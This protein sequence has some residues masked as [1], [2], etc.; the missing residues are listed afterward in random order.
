MTSFA[1]F[2]TAAPELAATVRE[3][4]TAHRHHTLATVR[5]DGAPRV[6]GTEVELA[7]G[8]LWI[9]S[10]R[11]AL[12][13][14]DLLRDGRYALHSHSEDP[15][16]DPTA[17]SGDVKVAGLAVAQDAGEHLRFRL[18][19]AEASFVRVEGKLLVIDVWTPDGGVRRLERS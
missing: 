19:V 18:G 12:K 3:R 8:E 7:G 5:R 13:A 6:S 17:W 9:G 16:D 11:E 10:G 2:E 15:P 1:A 4:F 14:R